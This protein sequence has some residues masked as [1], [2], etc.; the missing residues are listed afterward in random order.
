LRPDFSIIMPAY[1]AAKFIGQSIQAVINQDHASWELLIV[2]DGSED[3]TEEVIQAFSKHDNRIRYFKQKNGGVANARNRGLRCATGRYI[4]FL[5][6]DDI[7]DVDFLRF[8]AAHLQTH[9]LVFSG[10]RILGQNRSKRPRFYK[11]ARYINR[12]DIIRNNPIGTLT[13]AIRSELLAE[14]YFDESF[15]GTED[16]DLWIELSLRNNWYYTDICKASYRMHEG[17]ISRNASRMYLQ[18]LAVLR[19]HSVT[20]YIPML[21]LVLRFMK[22]KLN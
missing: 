2:N 20:S 8:N 14:Y 9:A 3:V 1:N 18:E 4:T 10:Y 22:R 7:W 17:G 19:K 13:V 11:K 21:Y 16:W 12:N 6:A 5:D 15:H